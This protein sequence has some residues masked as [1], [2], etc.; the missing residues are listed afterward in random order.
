MHWSILNDPRARDTVKN[1]VRL[2][3]DWLRLLATKQ[4]AISAITETTT[5]KSISEAD[6]AKAY[7]DPL[8]SSVAVQVLDVGSV[9]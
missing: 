6:P 5:A 9:F 1:Q 2:R 4:P 8:P 7:R 3:Q